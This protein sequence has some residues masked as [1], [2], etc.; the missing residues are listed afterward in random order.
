MWYFG[1]DPLL[2]RLPIRDLPLHTL[3]LE[4][5]DDVLPR[6]RGRYLAASTTLL[7]GGYARTAEQ[8]AM[9]NAA[10][11]LRNQKPAARTTTFLIFDFTG[12]ATARRKAISEP[13]TR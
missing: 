9:R 13:Q 4:K 2:E 10:E 12:D 8:K 7:Y 6:V 11:F 1:T 5:P 3:P